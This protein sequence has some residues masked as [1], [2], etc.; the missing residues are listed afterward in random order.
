M[1]LLSEV[2][3]WCMGAAERFGD[4]SATTGQIFARF[5]P[6]PPPVYDDIIAAYD[7]DTLLLSLEHGRVVPLDIDTDGPVV[8]EETR[9]LIAFGI[10][11]ICDGLWTL[12]PSLNVPGAIHA[13]VCIYDVPAAAPW[14]NRII[15]VSSFSRG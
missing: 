15:V 5:V 11:K 8:D 3:Q 12:R 10:D 2:E 6:R 7:G 4:P 13:F 1:K 9:E 14:E